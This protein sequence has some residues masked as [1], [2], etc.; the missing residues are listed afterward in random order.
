MSWVPVRRFSA[1]AVVAVGLLL[2]SGVAQ[3]LG[4]VADWGALTGTTYGRL[5][6]VKVG[7]VAVALA[8]AAIS[9]SVLHS[10]LGGPSGERR[11][12]LLGRTVAAETALLVAVLAVTSAL[13]AATPAAAAYR[14]AQ[15]RIL[16]VGPV[17]LDVS[18]VSDSPRTLDLH[19]YAYGPD[20]A[21]ADVPEIHAQATPPVR[22]S[23]LGQVS[24]P[25]IQAGTGHFLANRL[26]LPR[27]GAWTLTLIVRTGEF[28]SH[29][30]TTTLTVR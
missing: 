23:G 7:L 28:D 27:T 9:T 10:R 16:H 15:E 30:T 12:D 11:A 8:V 3:G 18:A 4:Q 20:G 17:T 14:P 22:A 25:L 29:T 21:L 26:M 2:A 19:L 13:V 24:I 1:V 6:L 5:L